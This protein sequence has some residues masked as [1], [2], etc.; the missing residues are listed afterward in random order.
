M[1]ANFADSL[2]HAP[3]APAELFIVEGDSAAKAVCAVRNPQLQ[4]VLPLQGKPVNALRASPGRVKASPWLA[5]LTE[6]LGN[7]AGTALPFGDLRYE[8]IILLMDPDADGIHA[9]ALVQI[10]FLQCMRSLLEQGRVSIVH[11]PWGELRVAGCE[12]QLAYHDAEFQQLCRALRG[13]GQRPFDRIR[14][15]G[16]G[17]ITPGIL[18]RTCINAGTRKTRVLTVDDAQKAADIFGGAQDFRSH[19]APAPLKSRS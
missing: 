3:G 14:H 8:R 16:L 1:I 13:D 5:A 15:R 19:S 7:A 10:F 12:P 2:R 11:A 18:E 4:A 6:V 9:G 17:T